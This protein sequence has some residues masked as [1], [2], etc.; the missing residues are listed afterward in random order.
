[1]PR[2][3]ADAALALVASQC[4]NGGLKREAL[5]VLRA[6]LARTSLS[7]IEATLADS[8]AYEP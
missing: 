8:W 1:M 7:R 3:L 2:A 6:A 4:L 5:P